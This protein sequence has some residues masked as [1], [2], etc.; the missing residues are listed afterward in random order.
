MKLWQMHGPT[1]CFR[2]VTRS[3]SLKRTG[4]F[5]WTA[6]TDEPTVRGRVRTLGST[7]GLGRTFQV[8]K[9]GAALGG[10]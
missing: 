10:R 2:R 1:T 4:A 5:C 7:V 3:G 6:D 9:A 8:V